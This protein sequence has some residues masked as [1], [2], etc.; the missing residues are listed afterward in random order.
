MLLL[1]FCLMGMRK[2]LFP[3]II[4]GCMLLGGCSAC[5]K[6]F[7]SPE[8]PDTIDYSVQVKNL[9][10]GN[11]YYWKVLAMGDDGIHSESTV[12]C[13]TTKK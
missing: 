11:T 12:G 13:F 6:L 10:P 5:T 7:I 2:K 1:G 3:M 9:V 4:V 8:F